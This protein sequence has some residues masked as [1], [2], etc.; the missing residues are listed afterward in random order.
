MNKKS[1]MVL[2]IVAGLYLVFLGVQI[3]SQV[4]KEQ[5]NNLALMICAA[6]LFIG[7]GV[8]YA[9]AAISSVWKMSRG[10]EK[11]QEDDLQIVEKEDSMETSQETRREIPDIQF[12]QEMPEKEEAKEEKDY[13]DGYDLDV[14]KLVFGEI[15]IS[16]PG[17]T[18]CKEDCKGICLICGANLNKGECGCDRDILDPRMS[19]FKDI[20]KNFKEV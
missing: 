8:V 3:I 2:R 15:L 20:L 10:G 6:V 12:K 5:P 19:V 9:G 1:W 14:D 11:S 16:M 17:K 18:L 4:T 7:V 13:I